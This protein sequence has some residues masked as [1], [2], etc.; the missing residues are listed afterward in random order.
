[1]GYRTYRLLWMVCFL[2]MSTFSGWSADDGG[3]IARDQSIQGKGVSGECLPFA[4]SLY[5][6]LNSA[7]GEAHL[8]VFD[9]RAGG[10]QGRHAMVVYLDQRGQYWGMDNIQRSPRRLDGA[11]N[12][13]E[14]VM[15]F[16]PGYQVEIKAHKWNTAFLGSYADRRRSGRP[17][18]AP[19]RDRLFVLQ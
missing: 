12:P 4:T 7:G 9:W 19:Q 18:M 10:Q 1:M 8:I 5:N 15:Q 16:A 17:H 2:G 3:F 14:W 11:D 6:R 13:E